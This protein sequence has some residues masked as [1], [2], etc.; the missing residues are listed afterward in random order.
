MRGSLTGKV[1]RPRQLSEVAPLD[2]LRKSHMADRNHSAAEHSAEHAGE[3]LH[4]FM[5]AIDHPP[6]RQPSAV[7]RCYD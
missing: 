3:V 6:L 1:F 4:P 2:L 5:M 7:D